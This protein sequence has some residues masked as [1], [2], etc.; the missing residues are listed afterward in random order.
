[1]E[2]PVDAPTKP[3]EIQDPRARNDNLWLNPATGRYIQKQSRTYQDIQRRMRK[4]KDLTKMD[5]KEILAAQQNFAKSH[6]GMG[7]T[8]GPPQI[9]NDEAFLEMCSIVARKAALEAIKE[10][11]IEKEHLQPIPRRHAGIS[12][13]KPIPKTR[14]DFERQW[15]SFS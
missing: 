5:T 14:S 7:Y 6:I 10:V 3:I 4:N 13:L 2:T 12:Q 15:N 9:R 1:M 8:S 11:M